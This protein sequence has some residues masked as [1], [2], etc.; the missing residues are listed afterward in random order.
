[1]Q[2]IGGAMRHARR[3]VSVGTSFLL[4]IGG[5]SAV[6]LAAPAAAAAAAAPAAA[7]PA[8]ESS[9]S[10]DQLP[11]VQIDGVVW[12]QVVANNMVYAGGTFDNARP[13]GAAPGENLVERKNL[14]AY[15]ITTGELNTSFVPK[16]NA[17]ALVV[18]LSPDGK[19][20]YAGGYFT[21]ANG[22]PRDYIV[23]YD[24]TTGQVKQSF[25]PAIDANVKAIYATD[26]TVYVG[27]AFTAANGVAR[28]RRHPG[29]E[30]LGSG[31]SLRVVQHGIGPPGRAHRRGRGI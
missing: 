1:M 2:R 5:V 14:L 31:R 29:L 4:T 27:G 21:F 24:L 26:T 22:N 3:W 25:A 7:T 8:T 6:A 17:S 19:T 12:S 30:L 15:D 11:T 13:A 23:A 20:L 28:T 18:A 16:L 9:V 10:A